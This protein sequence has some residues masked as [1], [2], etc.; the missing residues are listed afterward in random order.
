MVNSAATIEDLVSSFGQVA[1]TVS[2][3]GGSLSE[4]VAGA[5]PSAGTALFGPLGDLSSLSSPADELTDVLMTAFNNINTIGQQLAA[6]PFPV[7]TQFLANQLGYGQT[8]ATGFQGA[9]NGFAQLVAAM[10]AALQTISDG[11]A[12]GN[13]TGIVPAL[14]ELFVGGG[15]DIVTP[16]FPILDIP[17]QMA[18]NF[19]DVVKAVINTTT[20]LGLTDGALS[21][22]V[23][24]A[25]AFADSV[26]TIIDAVGDGNT[27]VAGDALANVP[28]ALL[29]A[30]L[31][32]FGG[33]PG[34][35]TPGTGL[36]GS[37]ILAGLLVYLPQSIAQALGASS[38][39]SSAAAVP[40]LGA[41]LDPAT[42]AAGLS[43]LLNPGAA[44]ADLTAVLDTSTVATDL[45]SLLDPGAV[46]G[47]LTALF[48]SSA[49]TDVTALLTTD[50]APNLS[51]SLLDVLQF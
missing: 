34:L 43:D 33:N 10:P 46:F 7:L 50:L 26:Q 30:V 36:E 5:L 32:G 2:D 20:F 13:V 22:P 17:G 35:L 27:T 47:N 24:A 44:L 42:G 1:G 11:L 41:L 28:A 38:T 37:G 21:P 48:E 29:G 45:T 3:P 51:G 18:Q 15:E 12:T 39:A 40:E 8:I 19:A 23:S 31:N 4:S 14:G 25:L 9:A 6:D 16:L 49:V